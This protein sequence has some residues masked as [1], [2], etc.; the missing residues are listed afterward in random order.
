MD[1]SITGY[2]ISAERFSAKDTGGTIVIIPTNAF[3]TSVLGEGV[4]MSVMLPEPVFIKSML[5]FLK[6]QPVTIKTTFEIINE[7]E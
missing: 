7:G 6:Q 2:V 5:A 4:P 3:W 1:H